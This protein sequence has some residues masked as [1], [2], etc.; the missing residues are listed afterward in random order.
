MYITPLNQHYNPNF[1]AYE[2]TFVI[3]K[4]DAVRR[5]LEGII[6]S[7]I[8]DTGLEVLDEWS[9]V[10][11][12]EM[13]EGNYIQYKEKPFFQEWVDFMMS[14]RLRAIVLGG[15]DAID[16]ASTLKKQLRSEYAPN[17]KRLNLI[18]CSDDVEKARKEIANFLDTKA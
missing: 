12:R 13:I 6:L 11:P 8:K 5:N 17:E 16:K 3:I 7:K 4:P 14:G 10:A 2:K 18:H 1:Q 9:G 15:D